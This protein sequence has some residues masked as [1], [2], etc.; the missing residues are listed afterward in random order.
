MDLSL[1]L[2]P[3]LTEVDERIESVHLKIKQEEEKAGIQRP[4]HDTEDF[5]AY[6]FHFAYYLRTVSPYW[7]DL[8]T[9]PFPFCIRLL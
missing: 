8:S 9:R 5:Y 7:Y 6:S 2:P 4:L 3:L 1:S